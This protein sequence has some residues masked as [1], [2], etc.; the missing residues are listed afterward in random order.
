M[1]VRYPS[2]YSSI[3][4]P[5]ATVDSQLEEAEADG[6]RIDRT[7]WS[8]RDDAWRIVLRRPKP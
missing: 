6:W 2:T 7:A 1:T 3:I 5:I 8:D 4:A